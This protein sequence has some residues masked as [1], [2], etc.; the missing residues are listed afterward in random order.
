MKKED[1]YKVLNKNGLFYIVTDLKVS[2]YKTFNYGVSALKGHLD[3][4]C[5]LMNKN[6]EL[7]MTL[8][9][10]REILMGIGNKSLEWS[11][12]IAEVLNI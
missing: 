4:I 10:V 12:H 11:S 3:E 9:K 7:E 8:G 5:K 6:H 1:H 2:N